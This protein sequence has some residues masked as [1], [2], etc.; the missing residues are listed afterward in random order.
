MFAPV[1]RLDRA[2]WIAIVSRVPNRRANAVYPLE[3]PSPG[4]EETLAFLESHGVGARCK[5]PDWAESDAAG[6][7]AERGLEPEYGA[8]VMAAPIVVS[9]ARHRAR[10]CRHRRRDRCSMD[11]RASGRHTA[12]L[13]RRVRYLV[14]DR[15]PRRRVGRA[16]RRQAP[17]GGVG[18]D[19]HRARSAESGPWPARSPRV[20]AL[21]RAQGR[22]ARVPPSSSTQSRCPAVVS[23][24]RVQ[25]H[26]FVL[27]LDVIRLRLR[28]QLCLNRR[29]GRSGTLPPH[30]LRPAFART[31]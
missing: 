9:R 25:D 12:R 2:G 15:P 8:D 4:W 18:S 30:P 19:V 21:V 17:L 24:R 27:V 6:V 20:A 5:V 28:R 3:P 14:G 1:A 29:R 26:R 13:V 16:G 31:H 10:R 22:R 23:P 7:L 11:G